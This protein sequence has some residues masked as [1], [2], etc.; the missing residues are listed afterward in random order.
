MSRIGKQ[1]ITIPTGVTVAVDN[2]TVTVTGPKG[3]LTLTIPFKINVEVKDNTVFVTRVSE[4][5]K[6]KACHGAT[7]AHLN[8]MI[9]GVQTPWIKELEI[10][11]TGYKASVNGNKLK[12]LAGYI[13]PVEITAPEGIFFQVPEETKIIVTGIDRMVVGQVASNIRKIRTPEP[14]K[15]K[16]IRYTDEF[17]KL[18]AGKKAKA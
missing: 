7:R 4:D 17:I 9:T 3:N 13:H 18:K 16:G 2:R 8:N 12:V 6:V 14:Y 11:G 5:K 15:G 10:K 1:P